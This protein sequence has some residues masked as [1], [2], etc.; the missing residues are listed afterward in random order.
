MRAAASILIAIAISAC[1]QSS[2]GAAGGGGATT[3]SA[4]SSS[5]TGG[6]YVLGCGAGDQCSPGQ[7]CNYK[8]YCLDTAGAC[9]CA[10][11][12]SVADGGC[13][14][15]CHGG[16]TM[17]PE[18]CDGTPPLPQCDACLQQR[19]KLSPENAMNPSLCTH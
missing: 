15:P 8:S 14:E 1:G 12:V 18:F 19:C 4:T 16:N 17:Y 11:T 10:C 9:A 13:A 7:F 2:G 6:A 3:T 5:G